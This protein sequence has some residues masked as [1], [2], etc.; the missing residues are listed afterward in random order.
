MKTKMKTIG[1]KKTIKMR[2]STKTA[3]KTSPQ[4]EQSGWGFLFVWAKQPRGGE[5]ARGAR[6]CV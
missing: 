4:P 3:K 1:K 2:S 6:R 5:D